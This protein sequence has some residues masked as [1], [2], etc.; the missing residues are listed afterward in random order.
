MNTDGQAEE[1]ETRGI[2]EMNNRRIERGCGGR[3]GEER[4]QKGREK[5]EERKRRLEE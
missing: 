5:R 2:E 1:E 4:R 3:R